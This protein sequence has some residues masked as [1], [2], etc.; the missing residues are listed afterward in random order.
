RGYAVAFDTE[1]DF[2]FRRAN[3]PKL[4]GE[5]ANVIYSDT[6]P[7][8][9]I[10]PGKM[11]IP[12]ELF[13]TKTSQ[14]AYEREWRMIRMLEHADSVIG[15]KIHL[16]EVGPESVVSIIFGSKFPEE[17]K[18]EIMN[19]FTKIVPHVTFMNTSINH[20]GKFVVS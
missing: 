12:K 11:N 14:W 1:T 6:P 15:D 10:D 19:K 16:F 17:D 4:C 3:D 9:Y 20:E 18:A 7:T 8:V 2:F 13:F 5:M